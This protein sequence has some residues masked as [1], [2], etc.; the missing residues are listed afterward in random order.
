MGKDYR[1]RHGY[2]R[3]NPRKMVA[4]WA[5]KEMRNLSRMHQAGLA[6]PKP[7]LLKGHVLVMEFLGD[8]GWPA[9][10]LKVSFLHL[11]FRVG[12][13]SSEPFL[14]LPKSCSFQTA[15]LEMP[16]L[17]KIYLDLVVLMRKMY[18][19]CRLVHAD[20]SEYNLIVHREKLYIIDVSQSVEH[21]HP[22]SLQF[23][24]SDCLNVTK[25]FRSKGVSC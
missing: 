2:C 17:E 18:R 1:Y 7:I 8:D 3:R 22:Y 24:R 5:E 21:D 16:L 4:T 15:D 20:L 9:P 23:L 6:V 14:L 10:L 12:F 25:F 13:I 19:S 11:L